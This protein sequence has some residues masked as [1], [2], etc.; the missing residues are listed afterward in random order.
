LER[1]VELGIPEDL[2]QLIERQLE[3]L[4]PEEQDLLVRASVAGLEFSTRTLAGGCLGDMRTL[5]TRCQ[6]LVRRKQF[7]QP[8]AT[9]ALHDGS[10][11]E[12]YGFIHGLYQH[13]LYR[14][15]SEPRRVL[16][17]RTLGEFQEKA[18]VAHLGEISAELATHFEQGRDYRLLSADNSTRRWADEDFREVVAARE[19]ARAA[20]DRDYFGL[21]TM[22]CAFFYSYRSEAQ[23]ACR[24]ADEG[25][26]IGLE[27][28]DAFLYMSCQYF[29]AW[30][31]LHSGEW[32]RRSV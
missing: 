9:I 30:A 11:P 25:M 13:A 15:V 31:L 7:L 17:H 29:K 19:A 10:L 32:V 23:E 24:A 8:A 4:S 16:L 18:Y 27:T 3:L 28:G 6:H 26:E 21:H 20:D 22:S 2:Q 1:Q 5:E 14:R 12:L